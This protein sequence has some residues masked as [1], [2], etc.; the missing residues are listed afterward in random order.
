MAHFNKHLHRFAELSRGWGIGEETFE[1]WSWVARQYRILA[2]LLEY[3]I[4]AG[5][6]LP[7]TG[8]SVTVLADPPKIPPTAAP[9]PLETVSRV[10]GSNPAN[11]LQHPGFYY[12]AAATCTR[13]RYEKFLAI[14]AQ[15]VRATNAA[16]IL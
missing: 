5:V 6:Q 16:M 12:H 11:A 3:A 4:R 1:F 14:A 13:Q 7:E 9:S 2:E 8:I 15:G 10:S